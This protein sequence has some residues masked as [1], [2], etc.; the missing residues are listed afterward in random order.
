MHPDTATA[1]VLT[2]DEIIFQTRNRAYGAFDLRQHYRPAL[3]RTL[4]LGVGLFLLTAF[5]CSAQS[6]AYKEW[7]VFTMVEQPPEFPGGHQ[8][9]YN[10]LRSNVQIPLEA[11]N[12]KITD[13]VIISFIVEPDGQLT[14]FQFVRSWGY[15][16]DEEAMRAVR[17]M[18]RWKPGSQSGHVQRV[19]YHL[20]VL[21]G[22]EY[23]K[24]KG[25]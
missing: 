8:A 12:A 7:Q 14:D 13:R 16:C 3:T 9:L 4:W 20:P 15:G 24:P 2:Y 22:I 25:R 11:V 1:V 5:G 19:K 21:F 23:P 17:A 18:P 10:Y 6:P